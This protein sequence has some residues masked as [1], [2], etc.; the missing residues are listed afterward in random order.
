MPNNV[1]IETLIENSLKE[2]SRIGKEDEIQ[3]NAE[4]QL[5]F[6]KYRNGKKR[7]SEQE[8]RFLLIREL[9]KQKEF[10]YSVET[11]TKEEYVFSGSIENSLSAR[12]DLCLHNP[13]G[14]RVNLIELKYDNVDVR[15]DFLKLLCDCET[16]QNYFVQFVGN[17]DNR[18]IPSIENKY[19]EALKYI[20]DEKIK[21]KSG[22]KIFLFVVKTESLYRYE[23]SKSGTLNKVKD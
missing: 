23:I 15:N 14:K 17:A 18:T 22:V 10:Y 9:E 1:T 2:L 8:L 20:L 7:I 11:P 12:I 21:I 4:S 16:E 5:I 3:Q 6:P 13:K 19:E